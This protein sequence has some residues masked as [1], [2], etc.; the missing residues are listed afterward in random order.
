MACALHAAH[1]YPSV[2]SPV[3]GQARLWRKNHTAKIS[4]EA[5]NGQQAAGFIV[6]WPT[7]QETCELP[8]EP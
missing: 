8:G 1:A 3:N 6:V 2:R 5:R 7:I 4:A